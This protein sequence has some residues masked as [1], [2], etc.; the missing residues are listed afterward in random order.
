[1]SQPQ[2]HCPTCTC[3]NLAPALAHHEHGTYD[4]PLRG[5]TA[6]PFFFFY[7]SSCKTITS[8]TSGAEHVCQAVK[9]DQNIIADYKD[10]TLR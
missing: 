4:P 1:M 3:E 8:I 7:C 6:P 9:Y 2:T 10:W 5:Q